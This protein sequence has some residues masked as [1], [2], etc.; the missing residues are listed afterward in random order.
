MVKKQTGIFLFETTFSLPLNVPVFY[1]VSKVF[2]K[3]YM[4][5]CIYEKTKRNRKD[6]F[7]V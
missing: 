1:G 4:K 5:R 3:D 7:K 6:N 2:Y